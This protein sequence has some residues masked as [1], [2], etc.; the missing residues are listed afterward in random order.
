MT[1]HVRA[2]DF[3]L[4][5]AKRQSFG[6]ARRCTRAIVRRATRDRSHACGAARPPGGGVRSQPHRLHVPGAVLAIMHGGDFREVGGMRVPHRYVES[7]EMGGRMIFQV[8][9]VEVGVELAPDTFTLQ[10]ST[11]SGRGK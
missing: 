5:V 11:E 7:T 4:A 6:D 8:E 2:L 3:C 9:R 10:P 1:V